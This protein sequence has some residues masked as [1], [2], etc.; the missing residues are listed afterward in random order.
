M[1]HRSFE[2]CTFLVYCT[3]VAGP[4]PG[5]AG[6]SM[7]SCSLSLPILLVELPPPAP[8][9]PAPVRCMHLVST[10]EPAWLSTCCLP[11]GVLSLSLLGS[12]GESFSSHFF[13][14][15]STHEEIQSILP[16]IK[17][18]SELCSPPALLTGDPSPVLSYLHSAGP[19]V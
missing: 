10:H 9:P 4:E 1:H 18:R 5:V 2:R 13:H 8:A 12:M 17:S 3:Q 6:G 7:A 19:P 16:H 11:H 14:A 15:R